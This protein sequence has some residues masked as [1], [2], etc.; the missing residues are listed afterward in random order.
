MPEPQS[1][2]L[3]RDEVAQLA[4]RIDLAF[5]RRQLLPL[6]SLHYRIGEKGRPKV[7]P[8]ELHRVLQALSRTPGTKSTAP[9]PM[10]PWKLS[11]HLFACPD[12]SADEACALAIEHEADFARLSDVDW[13]KGFEDLID[14]LR[15]TLSGLSALGAPEIRLVP[16]T[17]EYN[18]SAYSQIF[19]ISAGGGSKVN[20]WVT[21]DPERLMSDD[22]RFWA[23]MS[24]CLAANARPMIIARSI[25]AAMF[26]L[27]KALGVR[28]VQHF[29]V[30][31]PQDDAVA[32]VQVSE[33]IGWLN[34]KAGSKVSEQSFLNQV[35][36]GFD[37]LR[38]T[39]WSSETGDALQL[40]TSLRL[41]QESTHGAV[42]LL[43][44]AEATPLTLPAGW[45]NTV[46]RWVAWTTSEP[47]RIQN[48]RRLLEEQ[49]RRSPKP[50]PK[51]IPAPRIETVNPA[52]STGADSPRGY[53][54]ETTVSRLPVRGF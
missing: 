9:A 47:L 41:H 36:G 52:L 21:Q 39:E 26:V 29:S 45:V 11:E 33:R 15:Q 38:Q 37:Y 53:G 42:S 35:S 18:I 16:L 54:R 2:D 6:Q 4:R 3:R 28:G 40:A 10:Q 25:D 34:V 50:K 17:S 8:Y 12:L 30:W 48:K 7:H 49:P 20:L 31:A 22:P 5:R 23:F 43:Q 32:L 14:A 13:S 46:R 24:D 51:S 44:W 27:F 19:Q 1:L